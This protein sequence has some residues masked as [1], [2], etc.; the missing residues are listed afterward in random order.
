VEEFVKYLALLLAAPIVYPLEYLMNE[1]L[2]PGGIF[3]FVATAAPFAILF[4]SMVLITGGNRSKKQLAMSVLVLFV[5]YFVWGYLLFG[6][7]KNV[8]L[9][10][11]II[12]LSALLVS[13]LV[14]SGVLKFE[15]KY[16]ANYKSASFLALLIWPTTLAITLR[17]FMPYSGQ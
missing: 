1:R 8:G 7:S 4:G 15:E 16:R 11:V 3:V 13:T 2:I 17:Y 9:G 12:E 5:P 6:R 14:I 10:N